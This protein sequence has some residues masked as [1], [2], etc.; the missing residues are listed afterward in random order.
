MSIPIT[1]ATSGSS[2]NRWTTSAPHQRAMPVTRM[3]RFLLAIATSVY[4]ALPVGLACYDAWPVGSALP[5]RLTRVQ[6]RLRRGQESI[7]KIKTAGMGAGARRSRPPMRENR[8]V[9]PHIYVRFITSRSICDRTTDLV[10]QG[11][12]RLAQRKLELAQERVEALHRLDGVAYVH[13]RRQRDLVEGLAGR[14]SIR[15]VDVV[16]RRLAEV[17]LVEVFL[18]VGETEVQRADEPCGL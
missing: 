12:F 15:E 10:E 3:R 4:P 1:S 13:V 8:Q 18:H 2:T 14:P 17:G 6:T 16:V 5:S 7:S 11:R 9:F